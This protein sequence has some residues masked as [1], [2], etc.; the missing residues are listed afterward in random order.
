MWIQKK[1]STRISR[2]LKYLEAKEWSGSKL[3]K[4]EKESIEGTGEAEEKPWKAVIPNAE[5]VPEEEWM[6]WACGRRRVME[7]E[8][9]EAG[10]GRAH[11]AKVSRKLGAE[12]KVTILKSCVNMAERESIV[13]GGS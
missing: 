13:A 9:C 2:I 10:W 6:A 5:E 7:A 12:L 8:I 11:R 4:R 3:R 1:K